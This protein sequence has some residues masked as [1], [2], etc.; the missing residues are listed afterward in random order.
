M[1]KKH[2]D[3]SEYY[4]CVSL[5]R[6][7]SQIKTWNTK[8][9]AWKEEATS[10]NMLF[11]WIGESELIDCLIQP[12]A[13]HIKSYWFDCP[14]FDN[15]WVARQ[16]QLNITQL[17]HRY[18][19]QLHQETPS[20]QMLNIFMWHRNIATDYYNLCSKVFSGWQKTAQFFA[21][22]ASKENASAL[23]SKLEQF[24]CLLADLP[25][26]FY[27]GNIKL[28]T[29]QLISLLNELHESAGQLIDEL[30]GL[31][32]AEQAQQKAAQKTH[33][34]IK[35]E[36]ED[37]SGLYQFQSAQSELIDIF[38]KYQKINSAKFVLLSGAAGSGK[39]HLMAK[40][41]ERLIELEHSGLLLIGE[42][43]TNGLDLQSQIVAPLSWQ[44][45]FD[46]L[47]S[48]LSSQ[49]EINDKTAYILIDA[50]NETPERGLWRAHL[51]A[52]VESIQSFPHI[53]LILSCRED[54][55]TANLHESLNDQYF[56]IT[57]H[58]FDLNFAEAVMAYLSGYQVKT[59]H[60]PTLNREFQNP[61]FL[62]TLCEAYQGKTL[63]RG[64][65]T[66]TQVIHD[67]EERIAANIERL[68][69]CPSDATMLAMDDIVQK[70]SESVHLQVGS[71]E[72]RAICKQHFNDDTKN[73]GL[74]YQ[75][76]SEGFMWEIEEHNSTLRRPMISVR[77]QYERF[78]DIRT[79]EAILNGLQTKAEWLRKWH[80]K[81]L[82]SLTD[83]GPF[84]E[85]HLRF[86]A[87]PRLFALG[88]L[89]PEKIGL[90]LV[91]C[92]LRPIVHCT[93]NVQDDMEDPFWYDKQV[94][95]DVWL[96][97]LNWRELQRDTK[98]VEKYFLFWKNNL[99]RNVEEVYYHLFK[100]ACIPEHPLNA[101]FLHQHLNSLSLTERDERWSVALAHE[102]IDSINDGIVGPFLYWVDTSANS[103]LA[104]Q[105]PLAL[106]PLL[107]LTSSSNRILRNK[108]TDVA[109][110]ILYK[111]PTSTAV[112]G[113]CERFFAV[114]D[115]YVKERL[116]AVLCGALPACQPEVV[117]LL[118]RYILEHF[119]S[120]N[121]I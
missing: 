45:T 64:T 2:P 41:A 51:P 28:Q 85:R 50:I 16:T 98:K 121:P 89:L 80:F 57:H 96:E 39:S 36:L 76:I 42:R 5:N 33:R 111:H 117:G 69:N 44:G 107:W 103:L 82:P 47:L 75:L 81:I 53:K 94:L 83:I 11:K 27:E 34:R 8:N 119:W 32:I 15:E 4:V 108:A 37:G 86:D 68:T 101:N 48:C 116:L 65:L 118:G 26:A 99:A 67:W 10:Q 55:L 106:T 58:G 115:P 72:A 30:S 70:M 20:E 18:T 74:Y 6:A 7:P 12:E 87:Q 52:L 90:E 62:K 23:N 60:Q 1:L 100:Y 19:P 13:A 88:L 54:L 24:E 59:Q 25:A 29:S 97:T 56:F 112:M 79:V 43:F 113:V 49:A 14:Y 38:Q 3:I 110:R 9:I 61:L 21:H 31:E 46:Q 109:I 91:E 66:F 105:V 22:K 93:A 73:R 102:D 92:P 40:T 77:L 120:K 78:A 63:P 71:A 84:E 17:H 114:N 104:A 35:G 95:W